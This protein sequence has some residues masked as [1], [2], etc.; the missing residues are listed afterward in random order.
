MLAVLKRRLVKLVVNFLFYFR[1]DEA[2][3]GRPGG[4]LRSARGPGFPRRRAPT[5]ACSSS[6]R[7]PSEPYCW[8]TAESPRKSPAA[9]PSVSVGRGGRGRPRPQP[10]P[11]PPASAEI[12]STAPG[13]PRSS[14]AFPLG[15][16]RILAPRGARPR[17]TRTL[18][19][20]G[21]PC[22]PRV[23]SSGRCGASSWVLRGSGWQRGKTEFLQVSHATREGLKRQERVLP[24][25][26]RAEV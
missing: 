15:G 3:V 19:L 17:S 25:I 2:E 16:R 7:S 4:A 22:T 10:R 18:S 23:P 21:E 1:T 11:A 13:C 6:S 9:S 20:A 14:W 8:S 26:W 12:K 24:Q 5:L